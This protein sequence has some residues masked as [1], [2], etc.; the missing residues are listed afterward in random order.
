MKTTN[1]K[2]EV[3]KRYAA[4]KVNDGCVCFLFI[5]DEPPKGEL[6]NGEVHFLS[7]ILYNCDS[8]TEI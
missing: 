7:D 5:G 6:D 4:H 1:Y 8:V 2:F 3:G